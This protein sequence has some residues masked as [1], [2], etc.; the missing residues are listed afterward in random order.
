MGPIGRAPP[1]AIAAPGVRK[2]ALIGVEDG[3]LTRFAAAAGGRRWR[4]LALPVL[5]PPDALLALHLAAAVLDADRL[6]AFLWPSLAALRAHLRD[7]GVVVCGGRGP[8]ATRVRGLR[9]GADFWLA[10]P[11]DP[12]EL[13]ARLD[14]SVRSRRPAQ[15][16]ARPESLRAGDL[17]LSPGPRTCR[18]AGGV[19]EL[20]RLEFDLLLHLAE[21]PRLSLE[22]ESIYRA[23]W[24][25]EMARGDRSV[26]TAVAKLRRK[27]AI[28]SPGF[29][30]LHTHHRVGYRFEAMP[31]GGRAIAS[32]PGA[33][34]T[35]PSAARG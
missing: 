10:G 7:V 20:T 9:A 25:Y 13:V 3:L 24:G 35:Q 31:L 30:Y 4:P 6:G 19:L 29:A 14:V 33:G 11:V 16:P 8:V 12:R 1:R 21:N 2:V 28:S 27:L 17:E 5:P 15:V 18:V 22:R 32:P 26:D 34:S 23:V